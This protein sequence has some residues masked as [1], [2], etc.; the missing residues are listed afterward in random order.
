MLVLKQSEELQSQLNSVVKECC[1]TSA[2]SYQNAECLEFGNEVGNAPT[3]EMG[4]RSN[5]RVLDYQ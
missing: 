2:V 5:I 4:N 1:V 3:I